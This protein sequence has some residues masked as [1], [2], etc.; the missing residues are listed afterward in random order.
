MWNKVAVVGASFAASRSLSVGSHIT[1]EDEDYEVVGV[2]D[3]KASLAGR[4][5]P[6]QTV[7]V[8]YQTARDR[9]FRNDGGGN[10]ADVTV[11]AINEKG[12]ARMRQEIRGPFD[13]PVVEQPSF[14]NNG[15]IEVASGT[16]TAPAA[17]L[18]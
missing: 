7:Y 8:P 16:T 5:D 9:L 12:C 3:T 15:T 18:P 1:L 10:F 6:S 2:L 17:R 4:D 11:A 14:T 13:K